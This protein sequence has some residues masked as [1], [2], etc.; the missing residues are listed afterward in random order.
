MSTEAEE[1]S[2]VLAT[3]KEFWDG[4]S[5]ARGGAFRHMRIRV[6][7]CLNVSSKTKDNWLTRHAEQS[8]TA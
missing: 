6:R 2:N 4:M 7:G 8:L 1:A 3:E 5:F